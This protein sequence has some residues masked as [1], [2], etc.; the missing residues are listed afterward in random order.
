MWDVFAVKMLFHTYFIGLF[1]DCRS[2]CGGND[3]VTMF[4]DVLRK[5]TWYF[6][7]AMI[8]YDV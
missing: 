7:L 3:D 2:D 8:E 5:K 4:Y 1:A 6:L